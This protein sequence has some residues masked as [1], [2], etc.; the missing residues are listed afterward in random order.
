MNGYQITSIIIT[1]IFA[2][3][4]LSYL[5]NATFITKDIIILSVSILFVIAVFL[6]F[7]SYSTGENFYF[8]VSPRRKKCLEEQVS[9][10][11]FGKSRSCSC[12][13]KGTTGGIVP[14]YEEWLTPE[15]NGSLW[16]RNDNWSSDPKDVPFIPPTEYVPDPKEHFIHETNTRLN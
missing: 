6:N 5:L 8:E 10:N 2:F 15:E 12:C 9:L 1:I 4:F 16:H 11:N 3:I 13:Q 7:M 14:V